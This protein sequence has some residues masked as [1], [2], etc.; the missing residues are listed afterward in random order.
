MFSKINDSIY[1]LNIPYSDGFTSVFALENKGKMIIVDSAANDSD[2]KNYILPAISEIQL[3]PEYILCS[4]MHEDHFGGMDSLSNVFENAEIMV[5][6]HNFKLK[7][8]KIHYLFDGEILLDRY[9]IINMPGHTDDSIGIIDLENN[10]LLSFDS[11]QGKGI[12]KY[13]INIENIEKYIDT[14][15]KVSEL[16]IDGII[17]SHDY[18][19]FGSIVFG[20]EKVN[21][22]IDVCLEAVNDLISIVQNNPDLNSKKITELYNSQKKYLLIDEWVIKNVIEYLSK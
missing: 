13:G 10:I 6:S 8:R 2:V 15:N 17:S 18:E 14:L 12:F 20:K 4:H 3:F 19:P 11:L 1:K 9:K 21:E 16:N 5:F 7:K 22:Y